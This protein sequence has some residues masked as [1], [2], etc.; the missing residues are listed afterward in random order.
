[1]PLST[2]V[3]LTDGGSKESGKNVQNTLKNMLPLHLCSKPAL[4]LLP[5][6][7]C[8]TMPEED[9][10]CSGGWSVQ[11]GEGPNLVKASLKMHCNYWAS[12]SKPSIWHNYSQF[13]IAQP[14]KND[15]LTQQSGIV[16]ACQLTL[17]GV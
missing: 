11:L 1:M 17:Y 15:W 13:I 5:Y 3:A 14:A 6:T 12:G 2:F 8:T 4:S 16:V 7:I 10:L 9:A